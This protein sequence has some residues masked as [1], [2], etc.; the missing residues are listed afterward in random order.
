MVKSR[1][2]GINSTLSDQMCI[3]CTDAGWHRYRFG[4]ESKGRIGVF[5]LQCIQGGQGHY[6]A[7][8]CEPLWDYSEA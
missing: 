4:E 5:L 8:H 3:I 7:F 6:G 2:K 1:R